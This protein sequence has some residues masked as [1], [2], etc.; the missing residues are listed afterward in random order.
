[1]DNLKNKF[2]K[3]HRLTDLTV[4]ELAE[5]AWLPIIVV[6]KALNGTDK[7]A[8]NRKRVKQALDRIESGD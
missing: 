3:L 1:M 2:D 4:A 6:E 5:Q 7:N 8:D